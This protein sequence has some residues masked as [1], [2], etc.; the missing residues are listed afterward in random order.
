MLDESRS[1]MYVPCG[2]KEINA[3]AAHDR[4]A[5][6]A[7]ALRETPTYHKPNIACSA[8]ASAK[9]ATHTPL[10]HS[11]LLLFL[12]SPNFFCRNKG[13]CSQSR[14]ES[15]FF[16]GGGSRG[17]LCPQAAA[18]R[19]SSMGGAVIGGW[20]LRAL[21]RSFRLSSSPTFLGASMHFGSTF[22]V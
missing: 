1:H 10:Q 13:T 5:H 21:S 6:Q 14:A 12:F 17:F 7:S 3:A 20:A 15:S 16:R 9:R 8:Y 2:K 18:E 4:R 22:Q 19:G 11:A